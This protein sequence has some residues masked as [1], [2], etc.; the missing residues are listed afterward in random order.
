MN[1]FDFEKYSTKTNEGLYTI[2]KLD[3]N[4]DDKTDFVNVTDFKTG[5]EEVKHAK[6][7]HDLKNGNQPM[8]YKKRKSTMYLQFQ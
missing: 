8:Q 1:K 4:I 5:Y 3:Y 2:F 6:F 7:V